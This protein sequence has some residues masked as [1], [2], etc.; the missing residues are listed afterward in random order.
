MLRWHLG[1]EKLDYIHLP[2]TPKYLPI[3][4]QGEVAIFKW[5][6]GD[7]KEEEEEGTDQRHQEE[8]QMPISLQTVLAAQLSQ[9]ESHF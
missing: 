3:N 5:K 1:A 8:A 2:C 6:A 7:E 4:H 9:P